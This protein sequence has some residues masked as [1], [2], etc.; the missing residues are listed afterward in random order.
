MSS[1]TKELVLQFNLACQTALDLV[2]PLK[3]RQSKPRLEPWLNDNV[4]LDTGLQ[5][6][7]MK[8]EKGQVAGFF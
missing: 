2:A 4:G 5:D 7:R 6:S 8:V 1:N 3:I